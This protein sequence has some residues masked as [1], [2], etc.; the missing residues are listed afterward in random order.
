MSTTRRAAL[1]VLCLGSVLV[2]GRLALERLV[3][4]RPDPNY[5]TLAGRIARTA[6]N[7]SRLRALGVAYLRSVERTPSAWE[8]AKACFPSVEERDRA[9]GMAAPKLVEILAKKADDDYRNGRV[10]SVHGWLLS[11]TE[12]RFAAIVALLQHL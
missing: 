8:L 6:R 10:E 2:G 4:P 11:R 3:P 12:A 9:L 7:R 1:G 5:R